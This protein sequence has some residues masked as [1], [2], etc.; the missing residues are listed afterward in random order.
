MI[1][2]AQLVG[3]LVSL[4]CRSRPRVSTPSRLA[5]GVLRAHRSQWWQGRRA[6]S[7]PPA[8]LVLATSAG[9]RNRLPA[10]WTTVRF[11]L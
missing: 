5:W 6:N 3:N 9:G 2:L 10:L 8:G 11:R 7:G 4:H 1:S